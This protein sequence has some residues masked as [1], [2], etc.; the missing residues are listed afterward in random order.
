M[1]RFAPRLGVRRYEAD[2]YY[3]MALEA[4]NKHNL[5]EAIQNATRALEMVPNNAE[6]LSARG[7]FYLEHSMN[8]EAQADFNAALR[9]H[10]YDVLGHYGKGM[11]AYRAQNWPDALKHFQA[12]W[13]TKPE[14]PETLYYLA[15]A[16]HRQHDN[17]NARRFMMQARHYFEQAGKRKHS[18]NA[19]RW[20]EEFTRILERQQRREGDQ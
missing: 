6:Y 19:D 11:L 2:E 1:A 5:E 17:D 8:A 20:I 10:A 4:Y 3:R 16:Y 13:A 15:L 9:I 12:A 18:R 14:R 7:L